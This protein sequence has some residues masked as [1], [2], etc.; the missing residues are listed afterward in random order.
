M[1]YLNKDEKK[2]LENIEYTIAKTDDKSQE[3]IYSL[4]KLLDGSFINDH[5][6]GLAIR[7][8]VK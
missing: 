3:Q 7:N 2:I 5:S 8:L 1:D 6:L 4:L